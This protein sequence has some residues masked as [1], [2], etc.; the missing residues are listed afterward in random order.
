MRALLA[1]ALAGCGAAPTDVVHEAESERP[2]LVE[3]VQAIRLYPD[4][5]REGEAAAYVWGFY[6]MANEPPHRE[7]VGQVLLDCG[8]AQGAPQ[9]FQLD[10]ADCVAGVYY[11]RSRV[12]AM[13]YPDDHGPLHRTALAH[14]MNHAKLGDLTGYCDPDHTD[15]SWRPGGAVDQA[16][17]GLAALGM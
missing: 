13:A 1:L 15:E 16:N 5:P 4:V 2:A 9:A 10:A 8:Y 12:A 14:E 11:D 6:G 3:R 7:W 17:A